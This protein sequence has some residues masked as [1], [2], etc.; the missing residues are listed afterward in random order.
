M[1]FVVPVWWQTMISLWE[2]VEKRFSLDDSA[3]VRTSWMCTSTYLATW[4]RVST[5]RQRCSLDLLCRTSWML[6]WSRRTFRRPFRCWLPCRS[7]E[8][9]RICTASLL[10]RYT[11]AQTHLY[12]FSLG[13]VHKSIHICTASLL[14]RYTRA[15]TSVLLLVYNARS[16][17]VHACVQLLAG[18]D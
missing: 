17:R 6:P 14:K 18:S 12:Y 11:R 4:G 2:C 10:E 13:A 15:H 8:S 1:L 3:S 7:E 9:L 16:I 5:R